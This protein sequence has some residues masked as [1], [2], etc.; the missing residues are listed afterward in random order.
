MF[1]SLEISPEN[2]TL[3]RNY[4]KSDMHHTTKNTE[5][6]NLSSFGSKYQL[7]L[8]VEKRESYGLTYA[9]FL[10]HFGTVM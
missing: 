1:F 9:R 10:R 7:L 3:S 4:D 6:I 8:L 2:P 5:H